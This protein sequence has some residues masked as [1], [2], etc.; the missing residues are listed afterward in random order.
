M[1]LILLQI[2]LLLIFLNNLIY[3][4]G[5]SN[6]SIFGIGDIHYSVGAYYDGIAGTSIAVPADL[7]INFKNPAL[8]SFNKFTALQGGYKF[9]QHYNR[10]G[11]NELWQ[12]NGKVI[13]VLGLF[14]IDT[15]LG[16]SA[17]FGI[18]PYSS[19]NFLVSSPTVISLEEVEVKALTIYQGLGGINSIYLGAATKIVEN[20][21]LGASVYG[22]FGK[23]AFVNKTSFPDFRYLTSAN[24]TNDI[25]RGWGF[26]SGLYYNF[27]NHFS[28]G[29]LYEGNSKIDVTR[30]MLISMEGIGDTSLT[31]KSEFNLPF[32]FGSGFSYRNDK[33]LI[34]LDYI[35]QNFKDFN[36]QSQSK[37]TFGENRVISFGLIRYGNPNYFADYLDRVT[38]KL[39]FSY[40]NMGYKVSGY[41][42][43]EY[44]G[45]F[46]FTFPLPGVAVLETAITL[47]KR[48]EQQKG[49]INEFF[50]RL[51]VDII[52]GE[53]WFK[54]FRREYER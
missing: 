9:N 22:L 2:L 36:Y 45:S 27:L 19:V 34:A 3:S 41:E 32:K 15:G 23:T 5:G 47:G 46:G 7:A 8:W 48:G 40:Q 25:Y 12:N 38:Y 28:I 1:R 11:I 21:S 14:A 49:L 10:D 54:P 52:I 24:L 42:I 17:S 33:I 6:Y 31:C 4:Q 18:S 26:K 16:I 20:L 35:V 13:G 51:S 29:A 43:T 53:T 30:E 37:A 44:A 50:G 39:G